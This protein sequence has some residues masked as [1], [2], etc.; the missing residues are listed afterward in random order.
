MSCSAPLGSRSLRVEVVRGVREQADAAAEAL[1]RLEIQA[2]DVRVQP[3]RDRD[4]DRIRRRRIA[5]DDVRDE[6][7]LDD[8]PEDRD[9]EARRA[10]TSTRRRRRTTCCAPASRSGLP[11]V[12]CV[13]PPTIVVVKPV[14]IEASA[15]MNARPIGE[16]RAQI[17]DQLVLDPEARVEHGERA[18]GRREVGLERRVDRLGG[19]AVDASADGDHR[20]AV[21]Q[22]QRVLGVDAGRALVAVRR[23]RRRPVARCACRSG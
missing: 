7:V 16:V 17:L 12:I 2:A 11:W 5:D 21:A 15:G 3:V 6:P 4:D 18:L 8:R 19:D 9:V 13:R 23:E 20:A 10:A 14:S 22:L 1:L